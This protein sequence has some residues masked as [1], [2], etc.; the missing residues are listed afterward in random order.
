[1][2]ADKKLARILKQLAKPAEKGGDAARPSQPLAEFLS[3]TTDPVLRS[4]IDRASRV[5]QATAVQ[6]AQVPQEEAVATLRPLVNNG[7]TDSAALI[8]LALAEQLKALDLEAIL[9]LAPTSKC[10]A[11]WLKAARF[12]EKSLEEKIITSADLAWHTVAFDWFIDKGDLALAPPVLLSNLLAKRPRPK[13]AG[14]A[15]HYLGATTGALE[16]G[17]AEGEPCR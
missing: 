4:A 13:H 2:N 17:G 16:L 1:M 10:L 7:L 3:R 5:L 6:R 9:P 14:K 15:Y 11:A 12:P 8:F